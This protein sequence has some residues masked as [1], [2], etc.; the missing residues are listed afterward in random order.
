[1]SLL[2]ILILF[3]RKYGFGFKLFNEDNDGKDEKA[4]V[5]AIQVDSRQMYAK[6]TMFE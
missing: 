5:K 3:G 1:M 2:V 6:G 4:F